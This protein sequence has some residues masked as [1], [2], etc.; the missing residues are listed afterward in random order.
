MESRGLLRTM[1]PMPPSRLAWSILLLLPLSGCCTLA[2]FFCGPDTTPWVSVRFETPRLAVMTLLEALRRDDP[3]IVCLSFSQEYRKRL[4]MDVLTVGL[5]WP[6][7]REE[8]PGLHVAGY[9]EVPEPTRIGA[10]RAHVTIDVAGHQVEIELVRECWWELRYVR[11]DGTPGEPGE[12]VS[13]FDGLA[14]IEPVD[15]RDHDRSRLVLRPLP[16]DHEGLPNSRDESG[17]LIASGVTLDALEYVA[18]TKKWKIDD[19]RLVP[20]SG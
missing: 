7:V 10:D 14:R 4:K 19:V 3:E 2:R 1:P 8:N 5:V 9:A 12:I 15:D 17:H 20:G 18:L 16:F 11:P 13:S 6:R